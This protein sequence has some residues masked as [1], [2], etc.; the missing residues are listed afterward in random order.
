MRWIELLAVLLLGFLVCLCSKAFG[1]DPIVAARA[2]LA[3]AEAK[4]R[5]D[6]NS[7]APLKFSEAY[8]RSV[9][10]GKPLVIW[11]GTDLCP[12]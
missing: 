7:G 5:P 2:A 8:K 6:R 10:T 3:E 1:S 9:D 4:V 11:V 12:T